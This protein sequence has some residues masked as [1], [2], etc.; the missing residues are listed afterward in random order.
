M[1]TTRDEGKLKQNFRIFKILEFGKWRELLGSL[2]LIK[3]Q[4]LCVSA[5]VISFSND[6]FYPTCLGPGRN[7]PHG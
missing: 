5:R 3:K 7:L 2:F 4:K 6:Q 1:E